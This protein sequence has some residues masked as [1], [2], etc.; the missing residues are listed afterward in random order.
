MSK[1]LL[2]RNNDYKK[3]RLTIFGDEDGEETQY[4]TEA[5]GNRYYYTS[6]GS[7]ASAQMESATFQSFL[8]FTMSGTQSYQFTLI[9]MNPEETVMIETKVIGLNNNGSKG[10]IMKSFGGFRQNGTSL[11]IIGPD[12]DYDTKS[13]FTSA[14]AS[15]TASGTQSICLC[16]SGELGE[17]I[18]WDVHINYTKGFQSLLSTD[19]QLRPPPIYPEPPKK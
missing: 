9:P 6:V 1:S 14:S 19:P 8:S 15:F 18:E 16:V 2:I 11:D 4:Y 10:Y 5:N 7:T 3:V 13:D 12:I 17:D